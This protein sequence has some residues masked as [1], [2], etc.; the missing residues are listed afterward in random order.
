MKSFLRN[1]L[2]ILSIL[3]N[4]LHAE[5][6]LVNI[7]NPPEWTLNALPQFTFATYNGSENRDY[8]MSYGVDFTGQYLERGGIQVGVAKAVLTLKTA[9]GVSPNTVNQ[10]NVFLSG[11]R[12]FTPDGWG[13]E[14]RIQTDLLAA[15]NDDSS[16]ET[17]DV[18][19]IAPKISFLNFEK[20]TY[21]D[22]GLASSRYGVSKTD[23]SSLSVL[24]TTPTLGFALNQGRDWLQ[25][26]L[27]DIRFSTDSVA[28]VSTTNRA[29][30]LSQTDALDVKW[31]HFLIPDTGMPSQIQLGALIGKRLYAVD[32]SNLYN[33]ADSQ[34]GGV[35]LALQWQLNKS[36]QLNVQSG[37]DQYK[38]GKSSNNANKEAL[39]SG[40][41][42]YLSLQNQW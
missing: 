10:T 20:T 22:L 17:N 23:N 13:G 30:N 15:F 28:S 31:I 6:D 37:I 3:S 14:L 9:A 32:G 7:S 39:Y 33:F 2:I 16:N 11:H 12:Q 1:L 34:Q 35:S 29:Q 38:A 4:P 25:F 27:F 18:A 24:Q 8:V 40:A 41:Y 42:L 36:N 21:F 26:R 19:V 5:G